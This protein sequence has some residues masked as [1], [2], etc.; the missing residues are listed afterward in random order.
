MMVFFLFK[1]TLQWLN[2]EILETVSLAQ[3]FVSMRLGQ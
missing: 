2:I 1:T 3:V